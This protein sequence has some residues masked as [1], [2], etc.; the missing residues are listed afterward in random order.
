MR[1][2]LDTDCILRY[3]LAD[4]PDQT[5]RVAELV[6][7]GA[8]TAPE[9]LSECVFA[10]SG[11]VYG[12]SRTEVADA[13]LALLDEIYCEH[14]PAMRRALDIYR[15]TKLDIP[16]CILAARNV[17]EG[18]PVMSFDKKLIRLMLSLE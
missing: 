12:F 9:F 15:N 2:L 7:D 18:V 4:V 13:L 14:L 10:L 11:R 8:C 3:L 5:E 17:V 6:R 1:T 16:D